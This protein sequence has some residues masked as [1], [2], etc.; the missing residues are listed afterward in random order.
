M[1]KYCLKKLKNAE[2][3]LFMQQVESLLSEANHEKINPLKED[4][5]LLITKIEERQNKVRKSE[6]TYTLVSLDKNRYEC[7]KALKSRLAA[8]EK[9]PVKERNEAAKQLGI[10]FKSYDNPYQL[11]FLEETSVL[12]NFIAELKKAKYAK[13][14]RLTGIGEFIGFLE[15]ANQ[16][17]LKLYQQRRDNTA[18]KVSTDV[19]AVRKLLDEQYHKIKIRIQSLMEIEPT[20]EL[21]TLVNKINATIDKYKTLV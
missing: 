16:D 17:F 10:V 4:L 12:N 3:L 15:Q 20:D 19:K 8:E 14:I 13:A 5:K 21:T 6:H 2:H 9:C 7:Y 18:E 11:N 1:N